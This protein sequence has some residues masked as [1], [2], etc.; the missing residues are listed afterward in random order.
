MILKEHAEP[1]LDAIYAAI[2]RDPPAGLD[3]ADVDGFFA[4]NRAALLLAIRFADPAGRTFEPA[5]TRLRE[6]HRL[7][8]RLLEATGWYLKA[9]GDREVGREL[10][11][12][13]EALDDHVAYE[14]RELFPYLRG[15]L[16]ALA[17][18]LDH[19]REEHEY[20]SDHL[21][22]LVTALRAGRRYE[23]PAIEVALHHFDEEE[24]DILAPALAA[25][26]TQT[27]AGG[28]GRMSWS[29]VPI[30]RLAGELVP[31]PPPGA[32][33]P[34]RWGGR[35]GNELVPSKV[36]K[37]M[38][39]VTEAGEHGVV[40]YTW[41]IMVLGYYGPN[42]ADSFPTQIIVRLDSGR[43][44]STEGPIWEE[45]VRPSRVVPDIQIGTRWLAPV[46]VWTMLV[47]QHREVHKFI[48]KAN[49]ARKPSM[50]RKWRVEFEQ[51]RKDFLELHRLL[52]AWRWAHPHERIDGLQE[53]LWQRMGLEARQAFT[54]HPPKA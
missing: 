26:L 9:P 14:N 40:A 17:P 18:A 47:R 36:T 43:H 21:F 24:R 23:G 33:A 28:P 27:P 45:L 37:G 30:A 53:E 8:R 19:S 48:E 4:R 16:P 35:R 3:A 5:F 7:A 2:R 29:E 6:E 50:K 42:L 32:G 49:N 11:E 38:R 52:A 12:L 25:G 22:A 46:E 39:V 20:V 1:L 10:A 13:I 51:A 15:Q 34:T 44:D 41:R 54:T 31:A